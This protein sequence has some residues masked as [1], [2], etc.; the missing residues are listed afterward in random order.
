MSTG[1]FYPKL[2]EVISMKN[3]KT[4]LVYIEV[5][6]EEFRFVLQEWKGHFAGGAF[7]GASKV[8]SR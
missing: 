1:F 8:Y 7:K 2:M 5:K 3:S 6:E 4:L